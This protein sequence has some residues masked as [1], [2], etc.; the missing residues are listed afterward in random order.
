MSKKKLTY[1]NIIRNFQLYLSA[2]IELSY[3]YKDIW[4]ILNSNLSDIEEGL[5]FGQID[6]TYYNYASVSN[7]KIYFRIH[8]GNKCIFTSFALEDLLIDYSDNYYISNR[9]V[10][11][12]LK[13][14]INYLNVREVDISDFYIRSM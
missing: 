7:Y 11:H 14:Y 3:P 8:Y 4:N 12:V 9:D 5:M 6:D 13:Y 1:S 10:R 2:G